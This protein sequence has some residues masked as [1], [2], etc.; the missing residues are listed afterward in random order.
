M[1][2]ISGLTVRQ[3][4]RE[5]IELEAEFV[6][7]DELR[8]QIRFTPASQAKGQYVLRGS[9]RDL[10]TGGMGLTFEQFLPRMT[11]GTVRVF[12]PTPAGRSADGTP[13]FE[14]IFEHVVKVRRSYMSS[15]QPTY[16]VGVSFIDPGPDLEERVEEVLMLVRRAAVEAVRQSVQED[17]EQEEQGTGDA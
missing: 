2:Q 16:G 10:S 5:S 9:L 15:H 3:H 14:V 6:I 7:A 17:L 1:A 11:E 12:S 4:E 8:P 13:L